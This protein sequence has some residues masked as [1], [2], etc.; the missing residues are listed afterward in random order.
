V[1]MQIDSSRPEL[2][3][4]LDAIKEAANR[5]GILAERVDEEQSNE[6]ITDRILA[7]ITTAQHVIVDLTG[8]RPNVFYEAG[9]AHGLR[10]I[11]IYIAKMGTNLHFD[12]KDYPVIF[13]SSLKR[14][15]DD[16]E[17]RLRAN[18][19]KM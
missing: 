7:A 4:V 3:D 11:P 16:L 12:L 17:A 6:R 2:D 15:K 1:A 10:K 9:F 19:S 14:L 8:E 5:C 13:F 18:A